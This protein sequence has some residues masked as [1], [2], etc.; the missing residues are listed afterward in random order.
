MPSYEITT[1]RLHL[2]PFDAAKAQAL[3][4]LWTDPAVRRY[5]WDEKIISR[6]QTEEIIQNSGRLFREHGLGLWALEAREDKSLIGF[7]GCWFFREPPELEMVIGLKPEVWGKGLATE[8][9]R[10][11]LGYAFE[12]L[13]FCEVRASTDAANVASIRLM[14]RLGMRHERRAVVGGLDTVFYQLSRA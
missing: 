6:H 1:E 4:Q 10:A 11:L 3:H 5:L 8:A 7:G 14:E 13:G 2:L 12:R 9:G